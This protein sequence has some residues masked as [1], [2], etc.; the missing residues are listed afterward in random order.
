LAAIETHAALALS[1]YAFVPAQ[2]VDS[3]RALFKLRA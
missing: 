2:Q 3:F 1:N